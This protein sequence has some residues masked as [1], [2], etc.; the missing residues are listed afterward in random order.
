MLVIS[1]KRKEKRKHAPKK[2]EKEEES[3][4][5]KEKEESTEKKN[6]IK[7][8]RKTKFLVFL[9]SFRVNKLIY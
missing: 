2:V 8:V 3:T 5:K 9:F 7:Q 6:L 1:L 4:P